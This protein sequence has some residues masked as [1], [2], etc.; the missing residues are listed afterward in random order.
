MKKNEDKKK[1][2]VIE[3]HEIASFEVTIL[4]QRISLH[5]SEFILRSNEDGRIFSFSSV[6]DWETPEEWPDKTYHLVYVG[7]LLWRKRRK[8]CEYQA[9]L[10]LDDFEPGKGCLEIFEWR[11]TD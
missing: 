11:E 4:R 10:A 8:V 9:K 2:P 3:Y 7:H 1:I 6:P 5:S